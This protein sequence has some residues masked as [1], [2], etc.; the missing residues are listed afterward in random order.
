VTDKCKTTQK[1][2][3]PAGKFAYFPE[4]CRRNLRHHCGLVVFYIWEI[5]TEFVVIS[6]PLCVY[7]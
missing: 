5:L 2:M 1:L 6:F 4:Q 3:Q 7:H